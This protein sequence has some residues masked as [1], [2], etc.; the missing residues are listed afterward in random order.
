MHILCTCRPIPETEKLS[1]DYNGPKIT[2]D[3]LKTKIIQR[4]HSFIAQNSPK[5]NVLQQGRG[6][7]FPDAGKMQENA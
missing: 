4:T 1:K 6:I 2:T 5:K 7:L 3:F